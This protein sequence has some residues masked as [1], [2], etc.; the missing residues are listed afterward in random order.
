MLAAQIADEKVNKAR[1]KELQQTPYDT[2]LSAIVNKD[3]SCKLY[4]CMECTRKFP[5]AQMTKKSALA[6]P[7]KVPW[8]KF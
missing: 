7:Q 2:T 6:S 5:K 8:Q 1:E 3:Y 4:S